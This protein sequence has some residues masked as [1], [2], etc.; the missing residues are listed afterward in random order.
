M[1]GPTETGT[2]AGL[3]RPRVHATFS[4]VSAPTFDLQSHSLH[5]D[6]SLPPQEVVAAAADAGVELLALSDHDTVAGVAEALAAGAQRDIRVVP[7]VEVSAVDADRQDLHI[8]G[9]RIDHE[10][11]ELRGRLK[12]YR[13]DRERRADAM[14]QALRELGY[15]LDE[16][17]LAER[18]SQGK[19]V[20]RPHIADAVVAH[21]ANRE[22]LEREGLGER[23]AFLV[24][25]LIQG[26]AAFRRRTRPTVAEAIATIKAAGG[27]AVWAHPFWDVT[28][29]EDVL[30]TIERFRACGLDGVE[31]FYVTHTR[32]Q[33]ELV[34]HRCAELGLLTTGSADFHGP[35]HRTFARFRAFDTFGHAPVL[36]AIAG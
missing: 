31:A 10:D 33:T 12:E 20:G 4:P 35:E 3:P 7:A 29:P 25:H 14:A 6:G 1:P 15:E 9:Y 34:V 16:E 8:L 22:R 27:L 28:E 18:R 36:G 5:S 19:P 26:K 30:A 11:A 17:S 13:D 21:P 24:E 23:S 32:E 2:G